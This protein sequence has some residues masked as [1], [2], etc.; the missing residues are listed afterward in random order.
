[1]GSLM[2]IRYMFIRD[3]DGRVFLSG[4][5]DIAAETNSFGVRD[6]S[7]EPG[8]L[9]T[10]LIEYESM[11]VGN[12]VLSKCMGGGVGR[13][14]RTVENFHDNVPVLQNAKAAIEAI[15]GKKTAQQEPKLK[16]QPDSGM[17]I[18]PNPELLLSNVKDPT[19]QLIIRG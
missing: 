10:G 4:V 14:Y 17:N 18:P 11:M 3:G 19:L 9:T 13:G 8:V 15:D 6:R 1:D 12:P 16:S 5:E 2:Q 7:L